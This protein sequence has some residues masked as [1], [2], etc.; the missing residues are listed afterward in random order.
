MGSH[1]E[2]FELCAAATAGE[3]SIGEQA[4]LNA[5]LALCPECR[6]AKSEYEAAAIKG[7]AAITDG[8][9]PQDQEAIDGGTQRRKP[10]PQRQAIA[11]C[12][13]ARKS[14]P[15]LKLECATVA[16][17][18]GHPPRGTPPHFSSGKLKR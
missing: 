16:G 5:H 12:L 13:S 4:R 11:V 1:E 17:C 18:A 6:R 2:F 3:L 8:H 15:S 9:D 10:A 7:A 14:E